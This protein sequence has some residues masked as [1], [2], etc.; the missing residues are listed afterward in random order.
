M[1]ALAALDEFLQHGG[2]TY[3]LAQRPS[4]PIPPY[5]S[6]ESEADVMRVVKMDLIFNALSRWYSE[7]QIDKNSYEMVNMFYTHSYVRSSSL[8]VGLANNSI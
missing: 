8:S 1:S 5:I 4:S 3:P 7:E 2:S 6:L